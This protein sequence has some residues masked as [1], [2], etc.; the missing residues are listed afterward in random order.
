MGYSHK[1]WIGRNACATSP[2]QTIM[3]QFPDPILGLSAQTTF[4]KAVFNLSQSQYIALIGGHTLGFAHSYASGFDTLQWTVSPTVL[5]NTFY[6]ELVGFEWV[7][8][9]AIENG[10][11]E[12][13]MHGSDD[14]Y[15]MFNSD[16]DIYR[17]I[18]DYN[19]TNGEVSCAYDT[20]PIR[21]ETQTQIDL[22]VS[23]QTQWLNDYSVAWN[24]MMLAQCNV[25]NL[26]QILPI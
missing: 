1:F 12:W 11:Y 4:F 10:L 15:F 26:T 22:Y 6:T 18:S 23:N 17:N 3:A 13:E 2:N 21:Q 19:R 9:S 7:Q 5:D 25:Q 20:C 14:G 8:Q 16:V 24:T